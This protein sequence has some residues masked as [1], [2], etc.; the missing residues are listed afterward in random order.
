MQADQLGDVLGNVVRQPQLLQP[1]AGQLRPDDVVV[2]ERHPPVRQELPGLGLADV[3]QQRGQPQP[4]VRLELVPLFQGD[5][6]IEHGQRVPVNVLVPV[7]LVDFQPQPRHLGQ[8]HIGN[9]GP[10]Q[11]VDASRWAAGTPGQEQLLEL[12]R[13]PL[14]RHDLQPRREPGHRLADVPGRRQP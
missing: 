5:G 14:G 3:M 2:M 10:D 12:D 13:L 1:A 8:E 4:Q 7:V 9:A 6:L 11:Q